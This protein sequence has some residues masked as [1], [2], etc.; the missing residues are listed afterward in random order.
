MYLAKNSKFESSLYRINLAICVFSFFLSF[1]L[2]RDIVDS[3][4]Q[5]L[6]LSIFLYSTLFLFKKTETEKIFFRYL[7]LIIFLSIIFLDI[8][9]IIIFYF[10][11]LVFYLKKENKAR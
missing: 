3:A 9:N 5:T 6:V 4:I 10:S 7:F 11:L 2:G 8:F 1:L